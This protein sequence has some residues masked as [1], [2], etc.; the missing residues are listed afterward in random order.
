MPDRAAAPEPAP[1]RRAAALQALGVLGQWALPHHLLGRLAHRAARCRLRPWKNALIRLFIKRFQVDL[2]QCGRSSPDQFQSFNDFFTRE[3]KPGARPAADGGLASPADAVV[4]T[5][6]A[7]EERRLLQ[8][9]G[10]R[11]SLAG[12]LNGDAELVERY[13]NGNFITLY[14]S[15]RD[16]HRVHIP[17]AGELRGMAYVPGRLFSVNAAAT[18]GLGD[19]FVRNERVITTFQ[20]A[21][22]LFSVIFVGALLVGSVATAWHGQV[23]PG[24]RRCRAW[25]Y[26]DGPAF[27]QGAEIGRFNMGSTVIL[28][29]EPG[30]ISW[31]RDCAAGARV[32][33]GQQIADPVAAAPPV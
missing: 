23:T 22:G 5:A 11:Y 7:I 25:R 20:S 31:R 26:Q 6:G 8:A 9:K 3:L 12:L 21:L 28:L 30:K 19:L 29:T 15:P 10:R 16:Y 32:Q 17:A 24:E 14:L 1:G 18:A 33:V 13:R 2:S 27:A 4:S